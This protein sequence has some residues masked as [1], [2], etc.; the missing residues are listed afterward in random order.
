M[1]LTE[2]TEAQIIDAFDTCSLQFEETKNSL[3]LK[4]RQQIMN[5][6][7][8][9]NLKFNGYVDEFYVTRLKAFQ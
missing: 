7:T 5:S 8:D 4:L 3:Y 6:I 9:N 1:E 2:F